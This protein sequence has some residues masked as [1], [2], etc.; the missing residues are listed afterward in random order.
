MTAALS[1]M[2][3]CGHSC[4]PPR[5]PNPSV[6][7]PEIEASRRTVITVEERPDECTPNPALPRLEL[8]HRSQQERPQLL[9]LLSFIRIDP[10]SAVVLRMAH[11]WRAGDTVGQ[12]MLCSYQRN[13]IGETTGKIGPTRLAMGG[14]AEHVTL[15]DTKRGPRNLGVPAQGSQGAH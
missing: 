11:R 2:P 6:L 12:Q 4:D 3:L 15:H 10:R 13:K 5:P 9:Y 1:P 8:L 14:R 7:T